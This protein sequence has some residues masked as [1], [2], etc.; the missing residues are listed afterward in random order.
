MAGNKNAIAY[1]ILK[2]EGISTENLSPREAWERVNALKN[3]QN[4]KN[5]KKPTID[6]SFF[7]SDKPFA[8]KSRM[9]SD[10]EKIAGV[11][12][13][14]PMS[15]KEAD[16]GKPNPKYAVTKNNAYRDNCQ[17]CVLA[18]EAR[19]RGYDVC[20][21]AYDEHNYE[22][23]NLARFPNR[24]YINQN[25][26]YTKCMTLPKGV[27]PIEALKKQTSENRRYNVIVQV[28][29]EMNHIITLFKKNGRLVFYDPQSN[30]KM[31]EDI[32]KKQYLREPNKKIE[33][34]RVDNCTI[35]DF[36]ADGV[37]EGVTKNDR[38]RTSFT[39]YKK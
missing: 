21:K 20:A 30:Q 10:P 25:G 18:F 22:M 31:G 36:V 6:W 24:A 15:L 26:E 37:L 28:S 2:K 38:E 12:C 29:K 11:K 7:E 39:I 27:N 23:R 19:L 17:S 1:A 32:F 13:G 33:V 8:P 34:F 16:G 3:Y 4:L 14:E 35:V 9:H 5:K